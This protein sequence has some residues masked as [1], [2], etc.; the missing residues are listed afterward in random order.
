MSDLEDFD[1]A[2]ADIFDPR[3]AAE[4]E[5]AR[6]DAQVEQDDAVIAH[7]RRTKEVYTRVFKN[8]NA[9]KADVDFLMRDLNWF[10]GSDVHFY[11]DAR[12]QDRYAGR[13]EVMQ[14]VLEYTGLDME[15]LIRR[16]IETQN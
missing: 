6:Y 1:H 3:V 8:G 7:L 10:A 13:K 11:Q 16:Y 15:V 12:E 4:L 14:R 2:E 9:S 5:G